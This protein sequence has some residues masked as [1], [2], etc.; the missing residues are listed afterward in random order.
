MSEL[1]KTCWK[2][3]INK[4]KIKKKNTKKNVFLS[5]KSGNP[6]KEFLQTNHPIIQIN[7]QFTKNFEPKWRAVTRVIVH[8]I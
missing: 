8:Q 6:D 3:Q 7:C 5:G 1:M 4:P 2:V